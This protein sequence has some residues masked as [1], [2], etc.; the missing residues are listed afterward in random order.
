MK[1]KRRDRLTERRELTRDD[2]GFEAAPGG[3]RRNQPSAVWDQRAV[4]YH[5]D[6]INLYH[7]RGES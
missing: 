1:I 4:V 3:R 7:V 6:V 2:E 5:T